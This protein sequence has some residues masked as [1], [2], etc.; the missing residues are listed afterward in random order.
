M[1]FA[2]YILVHGIA[3]DPISVG[4]NYRFEEEFWSSQSHY[5][6]VIDNPNRYWNRADADE[7]HGKATASDQALQDEKKVT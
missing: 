6:D 5:L 4:F 3:N 2:V 7:I 1:C